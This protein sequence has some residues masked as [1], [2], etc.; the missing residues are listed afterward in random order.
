M[1][2]RSGFRPGDPVIFRQPKLGLKPGRRARQV[3]PF[4]RG[5]GYAYVVDKLWVVAEAR[6]E[7]TLVMRTRRGKMR[8]VQASDEKLRRPTLWERLLYRGRFP[9]LDEAASS[10][11]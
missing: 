6:P 8:V 7:G 2:H 4:P 1:P 11:A 3:R 9:R 5:D 10:E